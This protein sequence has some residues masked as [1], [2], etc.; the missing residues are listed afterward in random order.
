MKSLLDKSGII[1]RFFFAAFTWAVFIISLVD[2]SSNHY[3]WIKG[4]FLLFGWL[5]LLIP[6]WSYSPV[7]Q[8]IEVLKDISIKD[9]FPWIL[10]YITISSAFASAIQLQFQLLPDSTTC[11]A[12]DSDI[13]GILP[14]Y[15]HALYEL[16]LM[17]TGM[18]TDL[19]HVRNL[20]CLF[21]HNQKEAPAILLLVTTYAIVSAVVL[22]NML[23]A[24]MSNTLSI[25]QRGKKWR[26]YQVSTDSI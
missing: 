9:M 23:I 25:A 22:L 12:E 6:L 21:E 11:I 24:I 14:D 5:V 20:A 18:D 17:T 1:I 10:L 19:K 16:I 2:I 15:I 13:Q 4:T 26:Q 8:L 7:Y 3:A